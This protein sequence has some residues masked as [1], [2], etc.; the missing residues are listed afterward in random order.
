MA[1][2]MTVGKKL[3]LGFATVLLLTIVIAVV[4]FVGINKLKTSRDVLSQ[5]TSDA[6]VAV[7]VPF[8]TIKQY[9]NQADLI[10]NQ[11]M[12]IVKDFDASAEQMD[13]FRQYGDL[14]TLQSPLNLF[15]RST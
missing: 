13:K 1:N 14:K 4:S 10:I 12:A 2:Q 5:R 7:Q 3:T 9:Q 15:E 8:W 11:D 6:A